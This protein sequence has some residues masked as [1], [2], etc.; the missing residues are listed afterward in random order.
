MS[1]AQGKTIEANCRVIWGDGDYE[2]DIET[3]DWDTWYCF[4][5]KDF[6]L[7]FGPPLTMTGMCNSQKQAWSE[8]ER[9]LDVWARQVQ[10][11]QPMTKAQWLEIFG[12]P[13]GCNIPVLEMFV[14]EAKKKGLNL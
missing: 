13:N 12:G 1:S 8:L 14:D 4:V 5:R 7:H 2:L 9:M 11:G 6:G 10:S 3:D